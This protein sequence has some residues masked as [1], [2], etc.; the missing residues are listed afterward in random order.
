MQ[1]A[2]PPRVGF[3]E[4]AAQVPVSSPGDGDGKRESIDSGQPV[5]STP[6]LKYTS[7]HAYPLLA[8]QQGVEALP[9]CEAPTPRASAITNEIVNH[10]SLF[11]APSRFRRQRSQK[12]RRL[13]A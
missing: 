2:G 4:P 7:S 11:I 5:G 12:Q 6:S 9:S 13:R 1:P 3:S 8:S 10:P